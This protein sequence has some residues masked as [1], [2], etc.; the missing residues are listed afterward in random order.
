MNVFESFLFDESFPNLAQLINTNNAG[1]WEYDVYTKKVTWSLGF[2]KILGYEPG[3]IE[4]SYSNFI[5]NL[6]YYQD[7]KIFLASINKSNA[8]PVQAIHIRLLT[9]TGYEWFQSTTHKQG[10]P[11][12]TGTL[13][14]VHQYKLVSLQASANS[15]AIMETVRLVKLAGWELDAITKNLFLSNEALEILQLKRLGITVDQFLNFIEAAY[16]PMLH[17]SL[18]ACMRIGRPFDL[19][20][21]LRTARNTIIWVK[22]KAVATIDELGKC[23]TVKGILQDIHLNKRWEYELKSTLKAVSDQNKRLQN[24]THIATHNLR[25][26]VGNLQSMINLYE[27]SERTEAREDIFN[28][29][30]TIGNS[31][32]TTIEHLSEIA[33]VDF[34]A[35]K[36]KTLIDLELL[37]KNIVNS[38]QSMIQSTEAVITSDFTNCPSAYYLPGY[39]ES[40]FHNLLS[41][42]LKYRHPDR[43]PEI[44]CESKTENDHIYITVEDN[45]LGIDLEQYGH[46]VF[47]MHQTFH[48]HDD[49]QGIG[50]FITRNQ[51][52]A[53]GG[54]IR[55]ESAVNVGTKF[56]IILT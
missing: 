53:M 24:F 51:V 40:I 48:S 3:E 20:V 7:K 29:I 49:A 44:H 1:V 38:L 52:E 17:T 13:V 54:S 46:K 26:Y 19:D 22:I 35:S 4:C 36:E 34:E 55:I 2:Y 27:E 50:L 18:D 37:F 12:I 15:S 31:L 6:L 30:K 21:Q 10:G 25:S 39:L 33:K 5:E 8:T 45:G 28:W 41:N 42:A 56:I 47:G 43:I 16:R 9:K 11:R 14:N 32:N 23:H